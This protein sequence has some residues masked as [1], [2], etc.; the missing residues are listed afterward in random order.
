M[1]KPF[2]V[3]ADLDAN[4]LVPLE[5]KL[6]E[7]LCDQIDLEIITER[8]YFELFFSSPKKIDTLLISSGLYT[9]E[10]HRHNITD[11]FV[12]TENV[13]ETKSIDNIT[14]IFKYSSTKE[15]FNQVLC[16]NKEILNVQ[17]TNKDTQVIVVSSAIGGSGKTTI[18]LSL[19]QSLS[20]NHKRVLYLSTDIIQ[21]FVFYLQNKG[22][23]PNDFF[24]V[25][26]ASE[27]ALFGMI[28]P[29]LRN[30]GFTYLPPFGR[31]ILSFSL[32]FEIYNRIIKAAR[33]A[34]EFDFIIVDSD[35]HLDKS[36]AELINIADKVIVN[37]LQDEYSTYKTEF[38][39]RNIDCRNTDKFIFVCNKFRRDINNDYIVSSVGQ[40]FLIA[41]YIDE[42]PL[43]L[44]HSIDSFADTTGIKNL[45]YA[46][47]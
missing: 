6:T 1:S 19:A 43:Y 17:I 46:L 11:I 42:V 33:A 34:K 25:F 8:E 5:D 41:E 36:K 35:M 37:V 10:L 44:Q 32:D 30:E 23:L 39:I 7:E 4:Y 16:K 24:K 47:S 18:S 2:V 26:N 45:A 27:D 14:Y 20:R 38:L 21:S 31:T 22:S 40:Q 28:L 3:L 29:Y 9:Q 12:L 13:D 15:I